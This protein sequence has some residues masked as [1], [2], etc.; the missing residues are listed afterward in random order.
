M[1]DKVIHF[2][3]HNKII[4]GLLTLFLIIAGIYS[5]SKLPI[6]A[7]PDIT[8]NQVQIIT[9]S[10]SL[11][12]LEVERL[13]T[14]PIEINMANIPKVE[15]IR[16]I[17]R[18]GLSLVTVVFEDEVDIYWARQQI[19]ERLIKASDQ[20][21]SDVGKPELAPIS[22]GLSEIYQY[23]IQ[24]KPGFEN[25][26]SATDLRTIQ[27]WQIRRQL[28][29]TKGVA[30]ISS[31]GGFVKQ[32]EIAINPQKLKSMGISLS[33]VFSA[34]E[35]NNQNAGGA[36]I[37]KRPNIWYIRTEG[38]ATSLDDIGKIV[39]KNLDSGIPILVRD[40][41]TVH[42][43][44]AI[45][46]G[47]MTFN[48]KGETV[49]GIVLM[50]KGE[51]S[52]L[53]IK[54]IKLKM[55]EIQNALPEGLEIKAFLDRSKLV[56]N[57]IQTVGFNLIEGALIVVFILVL[58]LNN[59][60]A[61]FIVASTI[62]LAM[63]F[64]LSMMYVFGFSGNLMSL[65]AIDFG[66]VVD[67]TVIIVEAILHQIIINKASFYS[68]SD[69]EN[70][71]YQSTTKIR[72]AA[73]FGEVIILIVYLPIFAFVGIEGKMFKPM[74]AT[75][76]FAILGALVLSLTYVPMMSALL[77][78]NIKLNPNAYSEKWIEK[79]KK[80]YHVL[81]NKAFSV[82]KIIIASL[83]AL[84]LFSVYV[85][86]QLGGVFIPSLEEGDF[87]VETRVLTGSSIE[88]TLEAAQKASE[89]L[90]NHFPEVKEV[91]GK[92]GTSEIPT[93]PMPIEA[94]DL[95]IVLK[96]KSEWVSARSKDDLANKMKE[97]LSVLA[98]V[99]FSFQQPIQMR[100]NELMTG[101]RQ[102]VAIKIYG[103]D[104]DILAKTAL[105]LKTIIE[106]VEGVKDIF[107]EKV[108]GLPQ[109][110]IEYNKEKISQYGLNIK[111]I[112][113]YIRIAFAGEKSGTVYEGERR[114]DLVL[115]FDSSFR[116]SILDINQVYIPNQAGLQI[117]LNQIAKISYK[118]GPNQI[119]RDNT[120]RRITVAFNTRNRDVE[121]IIEE[122][123]SKLNQKLI[124]PPNYHL[125]YGGE[126]KKLIDAKARLLITLP[127]ALL[128]ILVL[129]Y[130]SF[131]SVAY[132]IIIFSS[133]P[134]AAI[135]GVLA[136]WFRGMPFSI[137]AGI[138]F[139]ALFGVAV[140]NGL[141]LINEYKHLE[142]TN[143]KSWQELAVFGSLE[144]FRPI[145]I[146][147]LV[148]SLGF[149]PMAF[150]NGA[151]AEVQKPLATVVIGGLCSATLLTLFLL[152]MLF[153]AYQNKYSNSDFKN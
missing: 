84:M 153:V 133:V 124:L 68:K 66:L 64:A 142:R 92:I 98:G 93:D 70:L 72:K 151:G 60:R 78:K 19:S 91:I 57:T 80:G 48:D 113:K 100:F 27:D 59:F 88:M 3:I 150:S 1:I 56:S 33:E 134:I 32:Y 63:L 55:E 131:N 7:V 75:V 99:T 111:E 123:K 4:V 46:Y 152:P 141:V 144:R 54:D 15:E 2:S 121:S 138:G 146:T 148:A 37:D 118:M 120:K 11:A 76:C 47:A 81:L 62:P 36:Y 26:Y 147:T 112:N 29:G 110:A 45:R 101:A 130:F 42:F 108:V 140:L 87:A 71:V 21:P 94:C 132:G 44:S 74:A 31:F 9:Y 102:D 51:N 116:K 10:P 34:L 109:I 114:F 106:P 127:L 143:F 77:L 135:G 149:L 13:I 139:I 129:L 43:G 89:I 16:S 117:P 104:L 17:S 6:D 145:L 50:L 119:E 40:I 61:G 107:I 137:S 95:I 67:G 14:F 20:I 12:S 90:L 8:N 96:D 73:A 128:L 82:Q 22:T 69:F 35:S 24:V 38:L 86:N 41:G 53:V 83:V 58:I 105:Q 136:L 122:I 126:Y 25:K 30:D 39:V 85:F 49:G 23:T 28:L 5:G 125:T 52:S 65:G 79:L 97:K 103:D 115:R 18:F